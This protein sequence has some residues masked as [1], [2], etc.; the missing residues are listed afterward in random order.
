MTSHPERLAEYHEFIPLKRWQNRIEDYQ[1]ER[2]EEITV[3]AESQSSY[4]QPK[5]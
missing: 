5:T 3:A 4:Q 1:P 2:D